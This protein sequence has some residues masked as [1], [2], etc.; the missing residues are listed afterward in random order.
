MNLKKMFY[1]NQPKNI[2]CHLKKKVGYRHFEINNIL[3]PIL[4][5]HTSSHVTTICKYNI[6][7]VVY[8]Y[9]FKI[10]S[11]KGANIKLNHTVYTDITRYNLHTSMLPKYHKQL[12]IFQF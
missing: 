5:R 6:C 8:G 1:N 3:N 12:S 2:L 11:Y 7:K 10:K 9:F 4:T